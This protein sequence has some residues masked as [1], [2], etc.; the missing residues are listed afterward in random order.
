[1][2][3]QARTLNKSGIENRPDVIIQLNFKGW[4]KQKSKSE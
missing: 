1:M 4:M 2:S 3:R